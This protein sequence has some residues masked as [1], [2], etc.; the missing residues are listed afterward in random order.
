MK[1]I[2]A[3]SPDASKITLE[4]LYNNQAEYGFE[5]VGVLSNPDS[6]K[7]RHKELTP[8]PVAAF[9]MEKGLPVIKA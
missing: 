5:I 6:A 9:A 2:Y 8:T 7:G 4:I 1:I 3:G